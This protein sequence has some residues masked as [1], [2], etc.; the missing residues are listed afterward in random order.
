M[1]QLFKALILSIGL[2]IHSSILCPNNTDDK[3]RSIIDKETPET[4]YLFKSFDV[5]ILESYKLKEYPVLCPLN[6]ED[7]IRISSEYGYRIHPI[8]KKRYFHR[9]VDYAAYK[10]KHVMATAD[11]VVVKTKTRGTYGKYVLLDHQNG[12]TTKYAHLDEIFVN[13]GDTVKM[14]Q[15]VGTV[16]STGLS[17]GSHLHYEISHNNKHIDPWSIYSDTLNKDTYVRY[18][19]IIN[20]RMLSCSD[21]V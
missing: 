10:G 9:G 5:S 17:T 18:V 4:L 2:F 3:I 8:Y 14:S 16:G 1:R 7:I 6:I 15:V 19:S 13:T 21:N 12:Y 20:D 11:G